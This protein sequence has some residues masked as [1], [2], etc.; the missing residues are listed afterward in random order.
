MNFLIGSM[1]KHIEGHKDLTSGKDIISFFS[2]KLLYVPLFH[3]NAKI[4]VLVK[5]GDLVKVGTL[6][7]HR[8]D[9]FYVPF[10]SSCSGIVKGIEKRPHASTKDIDHLVI[11]SDLKFEIDENLS[12][13]DYQQ[14]SIQEIVDFI[15]EK[16]IIGKG[17]AGFP[18]YI[19][20]NGAKGIHTLIINA[21]ECEPYI[22][23][24]YISIKENLNCFKDGILALLKASGGN[25]CKL[26]IKEDKKELIS[27]LKE[28]FVNNP[29]VVV[30]SVPNVYP[31]GWERT[32]IY[33]VTKKRYEKLPSEL[34][35][36]VSNA[37]TAI[38]FG[39]AM[40]TGVPI[41][42]TV[43][44]FSGD[45][46]NNP[47][48]VLCPVGTVVSEII[49][50]LGNLNTDNVQ[51]IAGGPMMGNAIT[52]DSFVITPTSNAITI[53][54]YK[55]VKEIDCLRC[56][57]CVDHCPS[58]L[59]PVNINQAERAQDKESL[60][61]LRYEQCIECGLCTYICP[62][63]RSVTE[64]IRRAKKFMALQPK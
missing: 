20:Y 27:K 51:I 57:L 23:A 2:S 21:V 58:G 56:G 44:T 41:T 31:M 35:V 19:K 7:A 59:Q 12:K 43:V 10:F 42:S 50:E 46:L 63:K 55:E 16:G 4:D 52:S 15:K 32:L 40:N 26:C 38:A 1:R 53:L 60:I 14:A 25:T 28:I 54:K 6:I 18:S 61:K 47:C 22:T 11:E 62:S 39:K 24:D 33:Q 3:A 64:G 13:L 45:A 49:S 5:E 9:H 8:N 29:E 34:G 36:I 48:N 17:G 37:T 30:T